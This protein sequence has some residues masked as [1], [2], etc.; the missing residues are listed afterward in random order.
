MLPTTPPSLTAQGT[1]LGTFQYMAPEQLEG[2]EADAR[3]DIFAFGAVLYEM[4]TGKKAFEGKTHASVSAAIMSSDPTPISALQP[5][6]PPALDRVVATCLAKD[7]DERWQSAG[8]LLRELKWIAEAGMQVSGAAPR[9]TTV[10]TRARLAWVMAAVATAA[11][12]GIGALQFARPRPEPAAAIRFQVSPPAGSS[13]VGG[14]R[15]FSGAVSGWP[16]RR[17][18]CQHHWRSRAGGPVVRRGRS[19]GASGDGRWGVSVLVARQP[20]HRLLCPRQAEEDRRHRRAAGHPVRRGRRKRR[21]LEPRRHHRVCAELGTSGLFRVS[22]AGGAPAP[23]TTLDAAKKEQAHRWPWFLPDGRRFL[24]VATPPTTVYVGS[25]DSEERTPLFASESKAIYAD[26]YLLFMRQGTL[27]AQSF[28]AARL[29][30]MGESFP[31]AENVDFN[32]TL[33]GAAFSASTTG[34]LTY[35][36]G[37]PTHA[38]N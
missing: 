12:L 13:I 28:D 36:T 33:G 29:R 25:L 35:R 20:V 16:A 30:T 17:L 26:G 34:G 7:P 38:R 19:A 15:C 14:G 24:Y 31:V 3:T 37:G 9:A 21:D 27:L 5:L 6:T 18:W 11:A 8:D 2:Q 1:I 4:L 32:A 22:A 10:R 23:V